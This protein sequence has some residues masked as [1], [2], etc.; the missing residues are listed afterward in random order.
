MLII[1]TAL[2]FSLAGYFWGCEH[3]RI[4]EVIKKL[5]N[6]KQE[7][8]ATKSS[9]GPVNEYKV[10]QAGPTGLVM[11]KTPQQLEY[12]EAEQLKKAQEPK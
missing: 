2:I 8:G 3:R 10:N 6:P 12:E 4:L 7:V 9:Y 11:P 1:T 5:E